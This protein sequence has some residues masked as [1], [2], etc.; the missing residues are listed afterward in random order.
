MMYNEN[1]RPFSNGVHKLT[2]ISDFIYS[3]WGGYGNGVIIILDDKI[4]SCYE[5]PDDGYRSYSV[6]TEGIPD[7]IKEECKVTFP[8][9]LV[10]VIFEENGGDYPSWRCRI[11]NN[12]GEL[13]LCVGTDDYDDYY[14]IGIFE[15]YPENLPINKDKD[16]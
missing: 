6:I 3:G 9:Q 15:Y 5:N 14:P 2:G 1:T 16:E 4:Y 7:G 10:N 8:P 11:T 12:E 13:I